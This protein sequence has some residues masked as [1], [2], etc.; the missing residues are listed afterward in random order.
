MTQITLKQCQN[1]ALYHISML[2]SF[3][4]FS[5]L[6]SEGLLT[7]RFGESRLSNDYSSSCTVLFHPLIDEDALPVLLQQLPFVSL[8]DSPS[9]ES[10][11]CFSDMSST[12][13]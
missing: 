2:G 12:G 4:V 5:F 13:P 3:G 11:C 10:N 9:L 8:E 7:T 6:R 1:A